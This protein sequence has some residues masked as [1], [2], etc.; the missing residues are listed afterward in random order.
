[1]GLWPLAKF[2]RNPTS[3]VQDAG[4]WAHLHVRMCA[5]AGVPHT[6]PVCNIHRHLVSKHTP[7]LVTIEGPIPEL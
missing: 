6:W 1:M 4:K 3:R 2:Q 5:P 7:N